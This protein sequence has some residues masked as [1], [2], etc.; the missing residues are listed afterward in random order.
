MLQKY[1]RDVAHVA[2]V[3]E[4][5]CK[6]Y[7]KCF[8]CSR[9]LLQ[10]FWSGCCICFT[11]MLQ[12]YIPNVSPIPVFR[13]SKCFHIVSCKCSIWMLHMFSHIYC[14]CMFQI[15]H[16]FQTYVALSVSCYTCFMLFE[17]SGGAGSD[18]GTAQTLGN[19]ARW[20]DGRL[21]A[22]VGGRGHEEC[23][24]GGRSNRGGRGGL[25]ASRMDVTTARCTYDRMH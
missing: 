18:G 21:H 4:T 24:E 3:S 15:F 11:H 5:Y 14:K 8:I 17:E 10:T 7:S 6:V 2:S 16:L 20:A 23:A 25:R 13:C 19:G 12:Q 9:R 1:I 22:R